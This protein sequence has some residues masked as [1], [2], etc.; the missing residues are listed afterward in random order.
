MLL[1]VAG[2]GCVQISERI[3]RDRKLRE[4]E[5]IQR[6]ATPRRDQQA[7]YRAAVAPPPPVKPEPVEDR[8]GHPLVR[9]FEFSAKT[10]V[11]PGGIFH[12]GRVETRLNRRARDVERCVRD[13]V[14]DGGVER[15]GALIVSALVDASGVVDRLDINGL[16]GAHACLQRTY[17]RLRLPPLDTGSATAYWRI[18]YTAKNPEPPFARLDERCKEIFRRWLKARL[19][20]LDCEMEPPPA[21]ATNARL[22]RF[23]EAMATIRSECRKA[24]DHHTGRDILLVVCDA[25]REITE[26]NK[27]I[28]REQAIGR[29][30]GAVNLVYLR[31]AG[32]RKVDAKAQ[33]EE[34][35]RAWKERFG[36]PLEDVTCGG[37]EFAVGEM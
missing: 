37:V 2:V 22:P 1:V 6:E 14:A 17:E 34:G 7:P 31:D 12:A 32:A 25:A 33:L 30:S 29:E 9:D 11:A 24:E 4:A 13:A 27:I 20:Q 23:E 21:C 16:D 36:R 3:Q 18:D 28:Q 35:R 15:T 26:A 10:H 8:I 19:D 5:R